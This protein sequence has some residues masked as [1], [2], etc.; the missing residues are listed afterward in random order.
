MRSVALIALALVV[1]L[2]ACGP[3]KAR[4]GSDG[5]PGSVGRGDCSVRVKNF[6]TRRAEVFYFA[7]EFSRLPRATEFWG[8]AGFLEPQQHVLIRA[9]CAAQYLY[10]RSRPWTGTGSGRADGPSR[11]RDEPAAPCSAAPSVRI[12]GWTSTP[13]TPTMARRRW[14]I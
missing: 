14:P 2:G 12:C 1:T 6:G 10:V 9:P 11:L 4:W 3:R 13:N 5:R 7:G 8:R